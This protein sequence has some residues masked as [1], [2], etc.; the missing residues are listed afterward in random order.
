[1]NFRLPFFLLLAVSTLLAQSPRRTA[2]TTGHLGKLSAI[3]ITGLESFSKK[4]VIDSV[5]LDIGQSVTDDDFKKAARDLANLGIFSD[6][7]YRFA[8][9]PGSV[10]LEFQVTESKQLL[11]AVFD[12]FI[13]WKSQDLQAKVRERVPLFHGLVPAQ[14]VLSDRIGD[15]LQGLVSER[16]IPGHVEY[17]RWGPQDGPI[18]K[19]IYRLEGSPMRIHSV[20]FPGAPKE[21]LD[22]LAEAAQ[23]QL[24]GKD[25]GTAI[26]KTVTD[27]DFKDV[28]LQRGY[29]E[30][31]FGEPEATVEPDTSDPALVDVSVPVTPGPQFVLGK[32]DWTGNRAFPASQLQKLVHAEPGKPVDAL[33]FRKDLDEVRKLYSTRGYLKANPKPVSQLEFASSTANYTIQV[34]EG[35]VYRFIEVTFDGVDDHLS[36]RLREAWSLRSGEPY[37]ATYPARFMIE[38]DSIVPASL[39]NRVE[40][41]L[42]PNDDNKTVEVTIRYAAAPPPPPAP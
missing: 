30:V 3:N 17:V 21:A 16:Q 37:D 7:A 6:V 2:P 22:P 27:F 29:L 25:Y 20:Q 26:V 18:E 42:S 13:W 38:T 39:R 32:V 19:I 10:T 8:T 4:D 41:N 15:A 35:A 31:K 14:G 24:L 40:I 5:P 33:Q 1:M 11:P 36:V 12:N 23:K 9:L 28:H 34:A